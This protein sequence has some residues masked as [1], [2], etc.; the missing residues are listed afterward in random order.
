MAIRTLRLKVKHDSY[1][2]LNKAAREVNAVWN[3]A[4]ETSQRATRRYTGPAIW[5]S[6]FDLISMASGAT[7]CFDQIGS[8]TVNRVCREYARKRLAAKR[9]QLSWRNSGGAKRS[10]GWIPFSAEGIQRK[11][12]N[13]RFCKKTIRVFEFERLAHAK[14]KDGCFAQDALGD[15]WLCL[16]LEV[17]E[18]DVPAPSELV[19][20]DLGLKNVAVTSD[21]D[22]LTSTPL[23]RMASRLAQAQRRGHKRQAKR[24]HRKVKR[25]RADTLH[26]FSRR[27]VNEYQIIRIGDVSSTKLT[28]TRMA[29]SA[30]DAGWGML[31]AQLQY[32]GQQ[33]GRSVEVVGEAYTTRAC[34]SCGSLCGPSGLRQLVVRQWCCSECGAEHDRDINAARNIAARF[35]C[36][37][38]SAGT[39]SSASRKQRVEARPPEYRTFGAIILI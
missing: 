34:S 20:I 6:G 8:A 16:P 30:L 11:T 5:L 7:K 12:K 15:W 37:P 33:A 14:W 26:K 35:R 24:I 4:N 21:G 10:L 17:S 25:Q 13:I 18:T 22:R 29:K 2:W 3:W 36:E 28:K 32:K 39:S 31:K 23:R 27:I 9:V 1:P 19:G 38:P